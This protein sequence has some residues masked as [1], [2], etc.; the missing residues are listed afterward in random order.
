MAN[1][2][3]KLKVIIEASIAPLKKAMEDAKAEVKSTADTI[4]A[5][6]GKVK[7]PFENMDTASA[8]AKIREMK[9]SIRKEL[10]SV[11]VNMGTAK[12]TEEFENQKEAISDLEADLSRLYKEEESLRNAGAPTA[13][14]DAWRENQA[15][16]EKTIDRIEY[17][18]KIQEERLAKDPAA[19]MT[20]NYKGLEAVIQL[21]NQD[22]EKLIAEEQRLKESGQNTESSNAW[23]QNQQDIAQATQK[24]EEHKAELDKL[25]RS[26]KATKN[27]LDFF[28][29]MG[30]S[31]DKAASRAKLLGQIASG[32]LNSAGGAAKSLIQKF[33]SVGSAIG[34]IGSKI[35]GLMPGFNLFRNSGGAMNIGFM[36]LLRY[37]LGI[38]SLFALFNRMRSGVVAG[39]QN[40]AQASAPVNASISMLMSSLT[41]LRNALATAF[42]PVLEV[43]AP[44]LNTLIQLLVKAATAVGAFFSALTGKSVMMK[45]V[46]VNQNYAS[47]LAGASSNLDDANS[48]LDDNASAADKATKA[49]KKLQ[50]TILGFDEIQKMDDNSDSDAGSGSGSSP[51]GRTPGA[52]S[53]GAGG[54]NPA[55][56]FEEVPIDSGISKFA[57]MF[58]EAWANADFTDIGRI[59]GEKLRDA[60]NNIPW[61]EIRTVLDKIA[62]SIATFLN[63]FLETPGLFYAIGNTIAQALNTAF[64]FVDTFAVNFHWDSL[65]T[66]VATGIYA[67][68]MNLNWELIQ[69]AVQDVVGGIVTSIVSFITTMPSWY[70]VGYS[71]AQMMNTAILGIYTAIT[72]F[73]WGATGDALHNALSGAIENVDPDEKF[74]TAIGTLITDIGTLLSRGF[75]DTQN[76][77]RLGHKIA[78]K[79]NAMFESINPTEL[80]DGVNAI[81]SAITETFKTAIGGLNS[82]EISQKIRDFLNNLNWDDIFAIIGVVSLPSLFNIIVT[83]ILPEVGK[84][85]MENVLPGLATTIGG[86][87]S[88][89][90]ALLLPG[91]GIAL[92][93]LFLG[94]HPHITQ[95]LSNLLGFI[96]GEVVKIPVEIFKAIVEGL[97]NMVAFFQQE[98]N[99]CGGNIVL[100]ILKGILD[101]LLGI[102]QW[103]IDNIFKPFVDGFKSAFG[104]HSPSTVMQEQG[105]YIMDGLK[106]GVTDKLD[107]FIQFFKDLPGKVKEGIG[108]AKE[109][110]K[111]KG[112]DMVEGL[113]NGWDDVKD[114]RF[115]NTIRNVGNDVKTGIGDAAGWIREKGTAMIEGLTNGWDS[116][117]G[118][119]ES[120]ASNTSNLVTNAIGDAAEWIKGKGSDMI[121]GL[122]NGWDD[123]E[124]SFTDLAAQLPGKI[125][126]SIGDLWSLGHNIISDFAQ[127]FQSI[128]IKLPH[129]DW[130]WNDFSL[131]GG[132]SFSL[133]SFNGIS[134]HAG[135][136]YFTGPTLVSG[137]GEA[138]DEA[139]LPLTNRRAMKNIAN[140]IVE[141]GGG[142]TDPEV[143]RAAV[144]DG[145]SQALQ[146]DNR[147]TVV[148]ATLKT[149]DDETLARAVA[150][151]NR[152][153][154]YRYNPVGT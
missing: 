10:D 85:F 24:L 39:F 144:A 61:D 98:I 142:G 51:K 127:G 3:E 67:A 25:S 2:V 95:G 6:T 128:D 115:F 48:G 123:D 119:L 47:S 110:I 89:L 118:N 136:G 18:N 15:A 54:I 81:T 17:F 141:A 38:R 104:I 152:K 53:G 16:I 146:D 83:N 27:I 109:W 49:N 93:V 135:G 7:S 21:L 88:Q 96:V 151:G 37:G 1:V 28:K 70:L 101:G 125:T 50:A 69:K 56:M 149:E 82:D 22:L 117:Q 94:T 26:G 68:L 113:R 30:I 92:A 71:L 90:P 86:M 42:A 122:R 77:V 20:G 52:G 63:G 12:Y 35:K 87:V 60:L 133:P 116:D 103:I 97:T 45:A 111:E 112:S 124:G 114:S 100:G 99:D 106:N 154:E 72:T 23:K 8:M 59:V 145:V 75:G 84:Y 57:D 137:L 131:P 19:K 78:D 9:R 31:T 150:R 66:A 147:E 132:F 64:E 29:G 73:N 65:G 40:L 108:N 102:G 129:I 80:A 34:K 36:N 120:R 43:V 44:I 13:G 91:I 79:I 121:T 134:W 14:T 46:K 105:G 107:G 148:Y 4:N 32:V 76:W 11:K 130:S 153:M 41:Q 139:V 5:E 62:K 33:A 143:I 74:G 126:D 140:S 55:D 58:K 138:G